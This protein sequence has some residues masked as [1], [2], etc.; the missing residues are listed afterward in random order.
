[1]HEKKKSFYDKRSK[2]TEKRVF[3]AGEKNR[4]VEKAHE[5]E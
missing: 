4:E 5:K 3:E 2:V 1:M